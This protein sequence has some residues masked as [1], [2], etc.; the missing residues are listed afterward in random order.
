MKIFGTGQKSKNSQK[1]NKNYEKSKF[2]H[3]LLVFVSFLS[4]FD[5]VTLPKF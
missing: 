4:L 5:P 2:H 1:L 3:F